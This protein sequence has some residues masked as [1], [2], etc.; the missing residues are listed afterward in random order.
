MFV[1]R[2]P[3][4]FSLYEFENIT[5]LNCDMFDESDTVETDYIVFWN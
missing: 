3:I 5:G 1:D 2:R 4:R